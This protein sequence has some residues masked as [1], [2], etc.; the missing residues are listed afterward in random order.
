MRAGTPA[1]RCDSPREATIFLAGEGGNPVRHGP[2]SSLAIRAARVILACVGVWAASIETA[3]PTAT[4]E[5]PISLQVPLVMKILT[6]DRTLGS[7]AGDSIH[8]GFL[9]RPD[10]PE[11]RAT[12]NAFRLEF[13]R[14][15]DRTIRGRRVFLQPIPWPRGYS[16]EWKS[17]LEEVEVLYV[18]R[19][20]EARIQEVATAAREHDVLTVT[21]IESF[22]EQA[23]SVGVVDSSGI[24][25]NLGAS[26]EEGADWDASFLR[27]CRIV[28]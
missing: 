15:E 26:H 6:Y 2:E 4:E 10:D 19:S 1:Q 18:T 11:D 22:V 12:L 28:R 21:G 14:L 5:L 17:V 25:I 16:L 13:E 7:V 9:Y 27:V 8:I 3:S 23:L 20:Q 24:T